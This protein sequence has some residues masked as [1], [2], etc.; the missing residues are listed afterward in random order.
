MNELNLEIPKLPWPDEKTEI[1]RAGDIRPGL[2][3]LP[4]S[5]GQWHRYAE[6]YREAAE[7]LYAKWCGD[8]IKPDYLAYPMVYL[9]RHYVELMLKEFLLSAKQAALIHLPK[10]WE[11][12]HNLKRLWDKILPLSRE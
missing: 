12:D 7:W 4:Q 2:A 11:C 8:P 10:K 1:F 9:Y 5:P 6:G 3:W